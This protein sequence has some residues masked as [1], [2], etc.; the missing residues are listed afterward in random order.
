[1]SSRLAKKQQVQEGWFDS[2]ALPLMQTYRPLSEGGMRD[3]SSRKYNLHLQRKN[4]EKSRRWHKK[5]SFSVSHVNGMKMHS[6][7][8]RGD[9][10]VSV[11]KSFSLS[12][13]FI[14]LAPCTV[15]RGKMRGERGRGKRRGSTI[16][17]DRQAK[18]DTLP[19]QSCC[20]SATQLQLSFSL[21]LCAASAIY[22]ALSI[23]LHVLWLL[24]NQRRRR[25]E[26]GAKCKNSRT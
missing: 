21:S 24:V 11:K 4:K 17:I 16:G 6:T 10:Y 19:Y 3:Q 22:D 9:V 25:R 26:K 7:F 13:P 1:M 14:H 20:S 8:Q 15:A 12:T 2:F 18:F 23:D 5:L